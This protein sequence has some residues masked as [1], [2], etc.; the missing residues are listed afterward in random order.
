MSEDEFP[1]RICKDKLCPAEL[2]IVKA[3][4]EVEVMGCDERLTASVILLGQARE[5][6]ADFIDGV[7]QPA[8]D[9]N[10][11]MGSMWERRSG[12]RIGRVHRYEGRGTG[13]HKYTILWRDGEQQVFSLRNLQQECVRFNA[14]DDRFLISK[15]E[16]DVQLL[17][18]EEC[19]AIKAMLLE[20]NK[21]YGSS[22]SNP[23]RIFSK[24]DVGEMINVR[25]DDKL[26]R[27]ARGSAAGEDVELD[28]MGYLIL[29]RV[30]RK[31]QAP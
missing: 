4:D 8:E 17:I 3:T 14:Q 13:E 24:V 31:M 29:K 12:D 2:S 21:A 27:L 26:S 22:F 9:P 28:L 11:L 6:V 25:L 30:L 5:K 20:K 10:K 16:H 15:E 18:A 23:L 1:R 19:D 7:R